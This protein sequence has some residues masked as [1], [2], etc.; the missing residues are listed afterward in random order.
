MASM[1]GASP[2]RWG[3]YMKNL[4][5][6]VKFLVVL[7][8]FGVFSV[9]YTVFATAQMSTIDQRGAEVNQTIGRA[10]LDLALASRALE[11]ERASVEWSLISTT[12]SGN[13]A[14]AAELRDDRQSFDTYLNAAEAADPKHAGEFEAVAQQG[15]QLFDTTCAKAFQMG[16]TSTNAAQNAVGQQEFNANC[17][18]AIPQILNAMQNLRKTLNQENENA[19]KQL[20]AETRAT[21]IVSYAAMLGGFL[22]VV[23]VAYFSIRA[24]VVQPIGA[25]TG[26]MRR[27]AENDTG[28]EVVG[29]GRG[30]EI[31]SMAAAVQVFKEN[32]VQRVRLEAEAREFQ[33]T[34]D[35]RLKETEAAFAA[36][37]H[38]Q[39]EVVEAM[40]AALAALARGELTVR[41][42][43]EVSPAYAALKRDFNSAMETLQRTV[44]SVAANAQGVRSGAA[45]ITQSSD[46]LSRRTEQQAASLEQTAAALDEITATV[47]K[48][49]EGANEARNVVQAAKADAERYGSV[50]SETVAAMSGIESSSKQISSIIG[51]IDEIAFQTNLLALNAGVEAARAGDAGRGFAVVATEVRALAQRSADAAKEIKAL[52]EASGSQVEAGVKLVGETGRALTRIVQ[53]VERLNV[54]VSDI[55]GSAQEQAA[56]LNQVNSAVNQMDQVT[57]QNAAMVEESTAASHALAEEAE[58]LAHLVGHFRL[59]EAAAPLPEERVVRRLV[60]KTAPMAPVGKFVAVPQSAA[61]DWAEF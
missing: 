59:G 6:I 55:A 32:A 7:G 29:V 4:P 50:A 36:S 34:L 44:E 23:A 13:D 21:I 5:I 56:G 60:G 15:D 58:A 35:A 31:G 57:Q 17:Q 27:L 25:I 43:H 19:F 47:R 16:V 2:I 51:V 46:D 42:S 20:G 48:T 24:G 45:E 53:Q 37:G 28:V 54:L 38:E 18:P 10:A 40:A 9:G 41:L 61:D 33:R 52:I 11:G 8:I 1:C 39:Q 26:V 12:Q 49:A 22:L 30:D 3:L 14:A